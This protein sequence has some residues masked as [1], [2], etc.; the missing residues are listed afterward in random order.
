MNEP[1]QFYAK[2]AERL[3]KYSNIHYSLITEV[4]HPESLRINNWVL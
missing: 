3:Y 1:V 4:L 2:K